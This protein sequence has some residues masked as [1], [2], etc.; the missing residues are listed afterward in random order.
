[1]PDGTEYPWAQD[2]D[3]VWHLRPKDD[4]WGDRN[5]EVQAHGRCGAAF[6]SV[7]VSSFQPD[8]QPM[9]ESLCPACARIAGEVAVVEVGG[10]E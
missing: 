3:G 7:H 6:G 4:T 9:G 8:P 10:G 1:M 5:A 2:L